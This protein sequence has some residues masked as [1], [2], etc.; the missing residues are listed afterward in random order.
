MTGVLP[1]TSGIESDRF[2]NWA[3]TTSV[4]LFG[5]WEDA[6]LYLLLPKSSLFES[7]EVVHKRLAKFQ[8]LFSIFLKLRVVSIV[9]ASFKPAF[10]IF[11][12]LCVVLNIVF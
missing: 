4:Y 1:R 7:I 12:R 6:S 8:N 5:T 9:Q 11:N 2:T 10:N 3:T